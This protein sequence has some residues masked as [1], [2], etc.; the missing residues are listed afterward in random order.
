MMLSFQASPDAPGE[1]RE[2]TA[3]INWVDVGIRRA[4]YAARVERVSREGWMWEASVPTGGIRRR[5]M[6]TIFGLMRWRLGERLV[7]AG[8]RLQG[9][10]AGHIMDSATV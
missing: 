9:T 6:A 3:V 5:G 10:R 4:D 1:R 2:E 8:E 7:R